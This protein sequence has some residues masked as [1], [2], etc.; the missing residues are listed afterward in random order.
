[1]ICYKTCY[2][3]NGGEEIFRLNINNDDVLDVVS[4]GENESPY[5]PVRSCIVVMR[6]GDTHRVDCSVGYVLNQLS[7]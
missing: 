2:D 7:R 4:Y 1:M 3:G 6:N 5:F